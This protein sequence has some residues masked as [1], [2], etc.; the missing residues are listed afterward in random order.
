MA[1]IGQDAATGAS[2]GGTIGTAITPGI[3]TAIGAGAGAL[4]G[5]GAGAWEYFNNKNQIA[6]DA[7]NRP[8]LSIPQ[9]F[10]GQLSLAQQQALQGM[11]EQT[12]QNYFNN[13][14]QSSA[15]G[16]QQLGTR[17]AGLA[18]V[19]QLNQNTNQGYANIASQSAQMKQ[20]NIQRYGQALGQYGDLKQQQWQINTLDPYNQTV[21]RT[22]ANN[23]AAYQNVNNSL[24]LGSQALGLYGKQ[25][26]YGNN[27][28]PQPQGFN[29]QDSGDNFD[30]YANTTGRF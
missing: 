12:Q 6:K 27:S 22:A 17:K 7:A 30:P 19:A 29:Q 24:Q 26:G 9:E 25:Q 14:R 21:A 13:L 2:I 15:Y 4:V 23:G 8:Q 20:A 10:Q 28:A 11:D 1:G 18:G 5:L 16:M 3:G